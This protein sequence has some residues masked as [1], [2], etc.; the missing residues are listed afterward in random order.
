M[1][2]ESGDIGGS[3]INKKGDDMSNL[4]NEN[5]DNDV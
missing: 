4:S 2:I 1:I 3:N 5:E